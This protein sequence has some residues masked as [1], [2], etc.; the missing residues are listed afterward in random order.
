MTCIDT[1]TSA[2][3][4]SRLRRSVQ[5]AE[6]LRARLV[7][8]GLRR[9]FH[10]SRADLYSWLAWIESDRGRPPFVAL[11]WIERGRARSLVEILDDKDYR[12]RGVMGAAAP[13]PKVEALQSELNRLYRGLDS[14]TWAHEEVKVL[15]S[16]RQRI[17]EVESAL[18]ERE[19]RR[20]TSRPAASAG[21]A[22]EPASAAESVRVAHEMGER[23]LF[24]EYFEVDGQ[25]GVLALRG[26][27]LL[28]VRHIA[29]TA[30][31]A[32]L[33]R[34]LRTSLAGETSRAA[35]RC[36][37]SLPDAAAEL[38]PSP[39]PER[40]LERLYRRLLAPV[41]DQTGLPES[42]VVSPAGLLAYVPFPALQGAGGP[43]AERTSI[44]LAPSLAAFRRF[45]ELGRRPAAKAAAPAL[46]FG[47]GPDLPEVEREVRSVAQRLAPPVR[48]ALGAQATRAAFLAEAPG[49]RLVH[50]ASHGVFRRDHPLFSSVLLADGRV[51]FYDVFRMEL[52]CDLVVLSACET[53]RND[54]A[55]GEELLGLSGGFL[56]AGA[57][58]VLVS[59]WNVLDRSSA[60]FMDR[61][62]KELGA[63]Q[64]AASAL[65][66]AMRE[67]RRQQPH[68]LHWA[69]YMLI[70]DPDVRI[71]PQR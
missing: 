49:A 65:A 57:R 47:H 22:D 15:D 68:P 34:Q 17:L 5:L 62:Y 55:P 13:D 23:V 63:G 50:L 56:Q 20:D 51:S 28:L 41:L 2:A 7:E 16:L 66:R 9:H 38:R 30:E 61:F 71:F 33:L 12:G 43:L 1:D 54:E 67:T 18:G 35:V 10:S 70:G 44:S 36:A 21:S 24:L 59:I 45:R 25:L 39:V 11:E 69:P 6:S 42:L 58:A 26:D 14:H 4:R 8:S 32:V 64:T 19:I 53:G 48:M 27:R 3:P 40:E 46:V 52:S 29:R 37:A 31:I 60:L